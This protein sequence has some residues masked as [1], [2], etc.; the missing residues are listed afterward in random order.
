MS[1]HVKHNML[2]HLTWQQRKEIADRISAIRN[3][4]HRQILELVFINEMSTAEVTAFCAKSGILKVDNTPYSRRMI[5]NIITKYVPEYRN[6]ARPHGKATEKRADHARIRDH[7]EKKACAFCGSTEQLELHH[8]IPLFL[9]GTNDTANL[10]WL[11]APCHAVVTNYQ[12]EHFKNEW[13]AESEVCA[14]V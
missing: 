10:V 4:T 2:N 11:C 6:T 9:G 12:R 7:A 13:Y 1:K 5:L 8:M 14:N 3:S